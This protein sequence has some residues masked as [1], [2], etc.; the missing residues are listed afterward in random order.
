MPKQLSLPNAG[1][2]FEAE[3]LWPPGLACAFVQRR[4]SP[5]MLGRATFGSATSRSDTF[6][7]DTLA[8]YDL[9]YDLRFGWRYE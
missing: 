8:Y 4:N 9:D 1:S 6:G 2:G 3:A 7:N 5:G